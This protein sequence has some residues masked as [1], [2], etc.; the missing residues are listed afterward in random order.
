MR[1][2]FGRFSIVALVSA[3]LASGL[4][5]AASLGVSPAKLT[6][7]QKA[8]SV[9]VSTCTVTAVADTYANAQG[10]NSSKNFGTATEVHVNSEKGDPPKARR[11]FVRFDLSSC[12]SFATASVQ[13][14][15]LKLVLSTAPSESRTYNA[16][17]VTA[18]WTETGLTWENQPAVAASATV[19][20]M[21]GTT[22]GVTLQWSVRTDVQAFVDGT[23]NHGWRIADSAEANNPA[24]L[25]IFSSK[26]GTQPPQLTITY[27][28]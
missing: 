16:H 23:A 13:S 10:V 22:G 24:M 20:T 3:L 1:N 5:L 4:G 18:A 8:S 28:P 21:T 17:R 14:A 15:A 7:L 9:P 27:Y 25:G 11:S 26:E 6:S 12:A 19:S 2:I